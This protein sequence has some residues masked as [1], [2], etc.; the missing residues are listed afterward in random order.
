MTL[1]VLMYP[2]LFRLSVLMTKSLW[3]Q[4]FYEDSGIRSHDHVNNSL[5]RVRCTLRYVYSKNE[6]VL[7][8]RLFYVVRHKIGS[9]DTT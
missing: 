5:G 2:P 3:H 1:T 4:S 6:F 8:D 9:Y 7:C